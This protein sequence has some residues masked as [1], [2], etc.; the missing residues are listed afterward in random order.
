MAIIVAKVVRMIEKPYLKTKKKQA[1]FTYCRNWMQGSTKMY[2][3]HFLKTFTD[4][5]SSLLFTNDTCL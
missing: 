2:V 5:S 3:A 1:S 4:R